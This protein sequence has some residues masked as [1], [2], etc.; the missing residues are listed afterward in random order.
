M[1]HS[2]LI[3]YNMLRVNVNHAYVFAINVMYSCPSHRTLV[4]SYMHTLL[5]LTEMVHICVVKCKIYL[6]ISL[7]VAEFTNILRHMKYSAVVI[8]GTKCIYL[9][10]RQHQNIPFSSCH[11]VGH[12]CVIWYE[13]YRPTW[14]TITEVCRL[15][16]CTRN[17]IDLGCLLLPATHCSITVTNLI[18]PRFN[19]PSERPLTP[20][21]QTCAQLWEQVRQR[22][23]SF[24][25][26]R[27]KKG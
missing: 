25:S 4:Y 24:Y 22:A 23:V 8:F 17:A 2:P 14:Q 15:R 21:F 5:M 20:T 7:T 13:M 19:L 16:H 1:L 18:I 26:I 11:E 10:H 3:T 27:R 12:V 6:H 9:L